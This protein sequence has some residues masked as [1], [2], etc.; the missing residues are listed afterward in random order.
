MLIRDT[1]L[2]T[3]SEITINFLQK[4]CLLLLQRLASAESKIQQ[5]PRLHLLV[6]Y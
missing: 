6:A 2:V 3:E 5:T 1:T 4:K